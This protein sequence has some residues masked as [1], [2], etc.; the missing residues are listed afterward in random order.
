MTT[1]FIIAETKNAGLERSY[2]VS[3]PQT[4]RAEKYQQ[5]LRAEAKRTNLPGFRKGKVPLNLIEQRIGKHLD[6]SIAYDL[7]NEAFAAIRTEHNVI[8]ASQPQVDSNDEAD[9]TVLTFDL[10]IAPNDTEHYAQE[11]NI[12]RYKIKPNDADI[13]E[14]MVRITKF[15]GTESELDDPAAELAIGQIVKIKT[16]AHFVANDP[17]ETEKTEQDSETARRIGMRKALTREEWRVHTGDKQVMASEFEQSLIGHK[18]GDTVTVTLDQFADERLPEYWHS[19]DPI[20]LEAELLSIS[21]F[22]AAELDEEFAQRLGAESIDAFRE[23]MSSTIEREK[24]RGTEQFF[25]QQIL[26]AVLTR[27]N[28]SPPERVVKDEFM[29]NWHEFVHQRSHG[30]HAPEDAEKTDEQLQKEY[31]AIS[32]RRVTLSY[33]LM[34]IAHNHGNEVTDQDIEN[35]LRTILQGRNEQEQAELIE[36]YRSD[37]GFRAAILAKINEQRAIDY[38][39][40]EATITES[41]I[42]STDF[43]EFETKYTQDMLDAAIVPEIPDLTDADLEKQFGHSH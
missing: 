17:E 38:L 24:N 26:D 7:I 18:V 27:A 36:R 3:Y 5:Q 10:V 37:A 4:Y 25:R 29:Q 42:N 32:L 35:E 21:D 39:A 28:F 9:T 41:E 11:L 20:C 19:A 23:Q 13:E 31:K 1:P 15:L 12:T 33:A 2:S 40:G 14:E 16:Q 43:A 6:E 30:Q 8:P 34:A 22:V